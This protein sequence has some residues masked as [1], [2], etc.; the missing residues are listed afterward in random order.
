M[1]YWLW[2]C[3]SN[4]WYRQSMLR[5]FS[6]SMSGRFSDQNCL[7][8]KSPGI[9]IKDFCSHLKHA[10]FESYIDNC[11][12]KQVVIFD[13]TYTYEI[14]YYKTFILTVK[15]L[16]SGNYWLYSIKLHEI[17]NISMDFPFPKSTTCTSTFDFK[18]WLL[19]IL[20]CCFS[21]S[22]WQKWCLNWLF[23]LIMITIL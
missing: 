6:D 19:N 13:S 9:I 14:W 1:Y 21:H 8:S 18:K 22:W 11:I 10:L 5:N 7:L 17:F 20:V 16:G 3:Q 4:M 2:T 15:F 23:W 12:D